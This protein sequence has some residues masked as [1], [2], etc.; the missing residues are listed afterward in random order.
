VFVTIPLPGRVLDSGPN[1]IAVEV[2]QG[3]AN[4]SDLSFSLEMSGR[5]IS[6]PTTVTFEIAPT[7]DEPVALDDLY[8]VVDAGPYDV[9]VPGVLT[10]DVDVDGDSLTAVLRSPPAHGSLTL[11]GD[12]SFRYTPNS[13]FV[14][15]DAFTY[16]ST[17]GAV[18]TLVAKASDWRYLDTGLGLPA[19][20]RTL[21]FDDAAWNLGAGELGY[22]DDDEATTVNCGPTAPD[23]DD[24]NF[25]TTYFRHKFTVTDPTRVD[26]LMLE[27]L[28][29]D[30]AI[31]YLNGQ[32]IFRDVNLPTIVGHA[33]FA[34]ES[35]D[36]NETTTIAVDAALLA[37]G[38]NILAVEVHQAAADSSDISFDLGLTG[39]SLSNTATVTLSVDSTAIE[40]DFN[41]DVQVN[42]ADIDLLLAALQ[43]GSI[44]PVYDVS[45]DGEVTLEDLDFLITNL[46]QT[47][48][49]AGTW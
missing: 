43:A 20:W 48:I 4:S 5:I 45:S 41:G 18:R 21:T 37:A 8:E 2:H 16:Q 23:C 49:G 22:G 19:E 10:N 30:A 39:R 36:E 32:Q 13:G 11:S 40:G 47:S 28:R 29:D 46:V 33:T 42:V 44:D 38:E 14:G 26:S 31:V 25:A 9:T 17:D 3:A 35:S 12:G 15:E 7:P 6:A 27:L 1:V 24:E 34:T